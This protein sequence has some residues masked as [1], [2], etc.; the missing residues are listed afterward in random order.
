MRPRLTLN[1]QPSCLSAPEL[2]PLTPGPSEDPAA[3]SLGQQQA[4]WFLPVSTGHI[5]F[6]E[7]NVK[8]LAHH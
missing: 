4:L 8:T 1:S 5:K 6:L 7:L 2:L 3:H